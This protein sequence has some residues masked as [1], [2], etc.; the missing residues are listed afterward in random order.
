MEQIQL[1]ISK[2]R[3]NTATA[4]E[5]RQLEQL[6][7]NYIT[8]LQVIPI[9]EFSQ[10]HHESRL[11][12]AEKESISN[13][14]SVIERKINIKEE[15]QKGTVF[16][17]AKIIKLKRWVAA[18]S[19]I[20][21]V[22]LL[23]FVKNDNKNTGKDIAV[24]S[25][26]QELVCQINNTQLMQTFTLADGSLVELEPG[27]SLEYLE[28]FEPEKRNILLSG[29]ATFSVAKDINRP[30][31]VHTGSII[32]KVLGTKFTIEKSSTDVI[33]KLFEGKVLVTDQKG[34]IGQNYLIPGEQLIYSLSNS[35][36]KIKQLKETHTP[37]IMDEKADNQLSKNKKE[38]LFEKGLI[39]FKAMPF[40]DVMKILENTYETAILVE[41]K[42]ADLINITA[43]FKTS[44]T[45]EAILTTIADLNGLKLTKQD[46]IFIIQ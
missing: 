20:A 17:V 37:K 23:F 32:T 24:R 21:V 18:A 30:F 35:S 5:L 16:K 1:L 27:S 29:K 45:L 6:L 3:D 42:Q 34:E 43:N 9:N 41:T 12:V 46:G 28:F 40:R 19:V 25:K 39:V 10:A 36:V 22:S 26:K 38:V 11:S 13:L 33:V 4:D 31:F 7:Y 2:F 14:L 44:D 15:K 8:D